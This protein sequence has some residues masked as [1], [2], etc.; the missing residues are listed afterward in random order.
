MLFTVSL[1]QEVTAERVHKAQWPQAKEG[2]ACM[3]IHDVSR[4]LKFPTWAQESG[5]ERRTRQ[6]SCGSWV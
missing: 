6:D 3:A 5:R 2:P 1:S 4:S